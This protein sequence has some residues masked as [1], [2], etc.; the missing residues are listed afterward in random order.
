[1]ILQPE[2]V[3]GITRDPF[4]TDA[5][6]AA[7]DLAGAQLRQQIT[8]GV[9]RDREANADVARLT[10]VRDDR[11]IDADHLAPHVEEWTT[12][13]AGIDRRVGLQD[14]RRTALRHGE[15]TLPRAD[16]AHADRVRQVE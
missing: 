5:D 8:H 14:L 7:G 2:F 3:D 12:G 15:R 1:A 13:V 11:G 9:D 6:A 16:H 4:D 10:A